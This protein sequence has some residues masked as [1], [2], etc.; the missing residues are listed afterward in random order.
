MSAPEPSVYDAVRALGFKERDRVSI[1]TQAP[2]SRWAPTVVDVAGLAGWTP[3]DDRNVWVGLNPLQRLRGYGRGGAEDVK[4][5]R[6]L[7][8]DLDVKRGALGTLAECYRVVEVLSEWLGAEP[9]VLIESGHGLQPLW[10]IRGTRSASTVVWEMSSNPTQNHLTHEE[11]AAL[12]RRWGILVQRAADHVHPGAGVDG[13]FDLARVYRCPGSVN[14]K[15]PRHP[16]AVRTILRP[17]ARPVTRPK[18]RKALRGQAVAR[19]RPASGVA[20]AVATTDDEARAWVEGLP[21]AEVP[22]DEMSPRMLWIAEPQALLR[23]LCLG[24][25][26]VTSAH[27]TMRNRVWEAVRLGDEGHAGLAVALRVIRRA[28]LELMDLRRDGEAPGEPRDAVTADR[29]FN[30]AV[31]GAVA[32][33]RTTQAPGP[34]IASDRA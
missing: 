26:D 6:V 27:E 4:R 7:F 24:T 19:T 25:A 20:R 23:D 30:R 9:S 3:P 14:W 12:Y 15:F 8:A 16:V 21:G 18:L 2:G 29:E 32:K 34:A 17:E 31:S 22:V 11:W 5:C 13:V 10:R 33:T 28:F 1:N